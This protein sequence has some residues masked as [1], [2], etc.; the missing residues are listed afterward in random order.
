MDLG[1]EGRVAIVVGGGGGIGG[2]IARALAAEGAQVAVCDRDFDAAKRVAERGAAETAG[3]GRLLPVAMDLA[4]LGSIDSAV[5]EVGSSLGTPTILVNNTGG[6]PPGPVQGIAPEIWLE[7]FQTMVLAV[8]ALTDSLLPGMREEGWGR[9]L[10]ST[11]FGIVEPIANLGISNALRP[12]LVGW[13]KTLSDEL[14]REGITSNIVVPGKIATAR[15]IAIDQERA[16]REDRTLDEV[17]AETTSGIALGRYGTPEE[18][19]AAVAFL[20]SR[21]AAYIT[22]SV[23]RIDGGLIRSV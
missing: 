6:P 4:D 20:A 5:E 11:S 15:A 2:G 19:G 14:G 17:V 22:G 16:D 23:I 18:Y 21:Q 7:H 9:I 8:V 3:S 12:A 10:T 13:S 1:I